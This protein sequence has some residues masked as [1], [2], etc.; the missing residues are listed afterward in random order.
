MSVYSDRAVALFREG[1]NCSQS[2]FAAFYDKVGLSQETALRVSLGLGGG[3]GRMR[4]VCGALCGAA[5]VAGMVCSPENSRD[6]AVR[7]LTY[8]KVQ[9]IAEEFQKTRQSIICHELLGLSPTAPKDYTPQ[10][11]TE[12]FYQ[13]RPCVRIVEEAARAAEK[14]LFSKQEDTHELPESSLY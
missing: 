3:V 1:Y 2:V 13:K 8:Q 7:A 6:R 11:R 4:E 14:V 10:P 9:Q 5:M 12:E